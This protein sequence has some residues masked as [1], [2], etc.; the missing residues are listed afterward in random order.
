MSKISRV[1]W[2]M[3]KRTIKQ[4]CSGGLLLLLRNPCYNLNI[5]FICIIEKSFHLSGYC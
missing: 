4:D 1:I 2:D 5:S 3:G